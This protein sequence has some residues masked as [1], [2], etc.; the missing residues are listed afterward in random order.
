MIVIT[1]VCFLFAKSYFGWNWSGRASG[2]LKT[3]TG[4]KRSAAIF[5]FQCVIVDV[6]S[7]MVLELAQTGLFKCKSLIITAVI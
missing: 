5:I 1:D 6:V 2:L 3:G 7:S 4:R